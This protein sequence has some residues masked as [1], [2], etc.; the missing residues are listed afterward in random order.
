M[1]NIVEK[2]YLEDGYLN[3]PEGYLG[4]EVYHGVRSQVD[5]RIDTLHRV[6]S[7]T[8]RRVDTTHRV[9]E[10][11][12]RNITTIHRAKEQV[13]RRVDNK[14]HRAKSQIQ[15]RIDTVHRVLEQILRNIGTTHR[16]QE[17]TAR[18]L[19]IIHRALEQISRRIDTLHRTYEQAQRTVL[20]YHHV[21]EQANRL[22]LV[23]H[24]VNEQ[25][26]RFTAGTKRKHEEI[27]RGNVLFLTC[28]VYLEGGYLE[29]PYLAPMYCAHMR[30]QVNRQET[31]TH[32]TR[33]QI[34]RRVDTLHRTHEQTQR[35]ID[36]THRIREQVARFLTKTHHVREQSN[37]RIDTDHTIHA[38]VLRRIDDRNRIL[39][40]INRLSKA[41]VHSQITQVLYNTTNLRI[42]LDFPSRGSSGV[43]WSANS[44]EPGDFDVNNLNTDI[45]EEVW[46]SQSG[47]KTGLQLTCDTEVTQGVFVDTLAFLNHNFTTS[48]SILWEASNDVGFS[49]IGF[50]QV[51]TST[52]TNVYYIA[53]TLPNEAFRYHRFSIDDGTN[54]NA[55][56]QIGTIVFGSSVIFQGECFV[57]QVTRQTVHFADKIMTEA[58]TNISND[59]ALKF[60]IGLE[61]RNLNF[62]KGNYSKI[63]DVFETAR[64]SFKCLWIPT[65]Q[66]ASR[67]A[68]FGKLPEIPQETHNDLGID[69]DYVN[70]SVNVDESL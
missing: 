38:Q 70:F 61:F 53:P 59:R 68:V 22:L 3:G 42:L 55:S 33:E 46:R 18:M 1:P 57:D 26:D 48:A 5:R 14:L 63:R 20:Q 25:V 9:Y 58:F 21:R 8:T 2:N 66:Y 31:I 37:R 35:R 4:G 19:G 64:T 27:R 17:Q 11:T 29:D 41:L 54:T 62:N 67:Y 49:T 12:L 30:S 15:Q 23:N 34:N 47:D 36:K 45:V 24:R 50:T 6:K 44:T 10:Q 65:P 28:G 51:L 7:Q 56:L 16:T 43:N 69:Q 40:Q 13:D 52:R 60:A 32:R 39:E